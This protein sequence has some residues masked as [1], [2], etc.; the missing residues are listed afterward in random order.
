MNTE[1]CAVLICVLLCVSFVPIKL[2][3]WPPKSLKR[4]TPTDNS[5]TK[6]IYPADVFAVKISEDKYDL[7]NSISGRES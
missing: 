7:P 1:C 5:R 6:K 3:R 4:D 2:K